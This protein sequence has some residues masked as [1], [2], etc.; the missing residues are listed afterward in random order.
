MACRQQRTMEERGRERG[1]EGQRKGSSSTSQ[2]KRRSWGRDVQRTH[3]G[4]HS[5]RDEG[6]EQ[7]DRMVYDQS[8]SRQAGT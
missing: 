5:M 2:D 8:E 4:F 6:T 7:G 1:R 3:W